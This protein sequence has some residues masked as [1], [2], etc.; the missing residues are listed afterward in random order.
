LAFR[1]VSGRL[2]FLPANILCRLRDGD[3]I[4]AC[5]VARQLLQDLAAYHGLDISDAAIFSALL[6]EIERIAN[7]KLLTGRIADDGS[8]VLGTADLL[9]YGPGLLR[10]AA[11]E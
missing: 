11:A 4:I 3:R 8:V 5:S 9:R 2:E 1:V 7:E 6:P 10:S